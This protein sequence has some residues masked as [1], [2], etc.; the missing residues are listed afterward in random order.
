MGE[1]KAKGKWTSVREVGL[2]AV[3]SPTIVNCLL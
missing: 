1:K 2:I 3:D